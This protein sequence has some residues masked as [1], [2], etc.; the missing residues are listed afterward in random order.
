MS[1]TESLALGFLLGILGTGFG[2]VVTLRLTAR[3]DRSRVMRALAAECRENASVANFKPATGGRP[4][5]PM[6]SAAWDGARGYLITNAAYEDLAPAYRIA[7]HYNVE[8]SNFL[9][10][11]AGRIHSELRLMELA[12]DAAE[13]FQKAETS[14]K[15]QAG[16]LL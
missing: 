1:Q 16:S 13:A 14:A 3:A 10:G 4:R 2:A 12:R 5:P 7:Q 6:F 15:R 8:L 9:S 11:T